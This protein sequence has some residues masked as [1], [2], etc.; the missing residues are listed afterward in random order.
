[1]ITMFWNQ[2]CKRPS[3]LHAGHGRDPSISK[4]YGFCFR[5]ISEAPGR[6]GL[7]EDSL[8]LHPSPGSVRHPDLLR[9]FGRPRRPTAFRSV[10]QIRRLVRQTPCHSCWVTWSAHLF[11]RG[12]SSSPCLRHRHTHWAQCHRASAIAPLCLVQMTARSTIQVRPHMPSPPRKR[13]I[14]WIG[15]DGPSTHALPCQGATSFTTFFSELPERGWCS[16][17][18]KRTRKTWGTQLG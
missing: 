4:T 1:M 7:E 11:C 13:T 9:C 17:T 5:I 10:S 6:R 16:A 15:S 8:A 12:K 2:P 3:P 18:S 14:W